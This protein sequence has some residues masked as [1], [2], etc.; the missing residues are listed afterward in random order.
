MLS[1]QDAEVRYTLADFGE[2]LLTLNIFTG[3]CCQVDVKDFSPFENA[4]F[5]FLIAE[6]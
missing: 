1:V 5:Q 6:S 4:V 3:E 2:A